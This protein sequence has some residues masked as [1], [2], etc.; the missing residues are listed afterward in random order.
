MNRKYVRA[1]ADYVK[2]Y[3]EEFNQADPP[4]HNWRPGSERRR[5][6]LRR[7]FKN[8]VKVDHGPSAG[9]PILTLFLQFHPE[10]YL[11][12]AQQRKRLIRSARR[13][14]VLHRVRRIERKEVRLSGR[15]GKQTTPGKKINKEN[16]TLNQ[17]ITKQQRYFL[18]VEMWNVMTRALKRNSKKEGVRKRSGRKKK[19]ARRNKR[20]GEINTKLAESFF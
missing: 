3:D 18:N 19:R 11:F 16:D 7:F 12:F 5:R 15:V 17:K 13:T 20:R 6:W 8:C 4:K 2:E 10:G 14:S 9:N 1:T